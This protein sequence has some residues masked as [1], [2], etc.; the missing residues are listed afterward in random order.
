MRGAQAPEALSLEP[1]RA[2]G[3]RE[4][5]EGDI[6]DLTRAYE[7]ALTTAVDEPDRARAAQAFDRADRLQQRLLRAT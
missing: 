6:L 5:L 1:A 7:R 4:T 3:S 2:S